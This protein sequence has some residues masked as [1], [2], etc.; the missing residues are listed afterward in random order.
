MGPGGP[1]WPGNPLGPPIQP[2]KR[3]KRKMK[4]SIFNAK[5]HGFVILRRSRAPGL[6]SGYHFY[7]QSNRMN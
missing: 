4:G 3:E 1:G 6:K 5:S 2:G 7:A